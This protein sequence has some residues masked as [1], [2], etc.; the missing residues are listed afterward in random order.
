MRQDVLRWHHLD[1]IVGGVAEKKNPLGPMGENVRANVQRIR[2]GAGMSYREL[3]DRLSVAGRP[4]PTLGLSRLENGERR[5][6][7]DDLV[8]LALALSVSP[9]TLL[10]P[11]H[12]EPTE[13]EAWAAMWQWMLAEAPL[14][15]S[16][17]DAESFRRTNRPYENSNAQA[18]AMNR[19]VEATG[20]LTAGL[21]SGRVSPGSDHMVIPVDDR[22]T[23]TVRVGIEGGEDDGR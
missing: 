4:I 13:H 19:I 10:M 12:P 17:I 14:P 7:V 3:S 9:A 20:I 18:A 21:L 23:L 1:A 22:T 5:V 6:D 11:E 16:D 15:G 8:A 2:T